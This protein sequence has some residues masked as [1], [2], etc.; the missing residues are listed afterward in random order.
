M[1]CFL[2]AKRFE[3]E[4]KDFIKRRF[5][6]GHVGITRDKLIVLRLASRESRLENEIKMDWVALLGRPQRRENHLV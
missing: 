5:V 1:L 3:K 2:V 6:I 4:L